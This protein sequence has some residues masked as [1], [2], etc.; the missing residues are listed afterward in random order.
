LEFKA[1][2]RLSRQ[3]ERNLHSRLVVAGFRRQAFD[4]EGSW[5]LELVEPGSG[6]ML[7]LDAQDDWQGRLDDLLSDSQILQLDEARLSA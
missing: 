4:D 6:R 3:I 1:A 7:T 5:A 2:Y